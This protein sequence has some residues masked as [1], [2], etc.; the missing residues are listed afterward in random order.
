MELHLDVSFQVSESHMELGATVGSMDFCE[1]L[2]EDLVQLEPTTE[3]IAHTSGTLLLSLED[4]LPPFP[5]SLCSHIEVPIASASSKPDMEGRDSAGVLKSARPVV[6]ELKTEKPIT[7]TQLLRVVSTEVNSAAEV[8]GKW[9]LPMTSRCRGAV[10]GSGDDSGSCVNIVAL[11]C[12]V[13]VWLDVCTLKRIENSFSQIRFPVRP[14]EITP[15]ELSN[16][17]KKAAVAAVIDQVIEDVDMQQREGNGSVDLDR[18]GFFRASLSIP[19]VRVIVCF[20]SDGR[21]CSTKLHKEFVT[22]DFTTPALQPGVTQPTVVFK[23]ANEF[24]TVLGAQAGHSLLL[25][26]EGATMFMISTPNADK[27]HAV[28]VL[29]ISPQASSFGGFSGP[30]EVANEGASCEFQWHSMTQTASWIAQRAWDGA[31]S[32]QRRGDGGGGIGGSSS[33]YAAATATEAV[34][35]ENLHIREEII[36]CSRLVIHINLPMVGIQLSRAQHI[37]LLKGFSCFMAIFNAK[38][39]GKGS[40]EDKRNRT[41]PSGQSP[42]MLGVLSGACQTSQ[43]SVLVQ[44]GQVDVLLDLKPPQASDL[45]SASAT[46]ESKGWDVLH[47]L[48]CKLQVP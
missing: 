8:T 9:Q 14:K 45:L 26:L 18:R 22:I 41:E 12:P 46:E 39:T 27:F 23:Y 4:S 10:N 34:E 42:S 32:Q 6:Q 2:M 11:L 3:G 19:C 28:R 33:E 7:R 36:G 44:C 15:R 25:N 21:Q 38:F 31:A 24:K 47:F 17:G 13:I 1:C 37:Q 35:E 40:R 29:S 30:N 5:I 48:I 43:I 20:P 16:G